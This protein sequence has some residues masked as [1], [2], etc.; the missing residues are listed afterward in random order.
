MTAGAFFVCLFTLFSRR[1]RGWMKRLSA[2]WKESGRRVLDYC[3]ATSHKPQGGMDGRGRCIDALGMLLVIPHC[4]NR[5]FTS[6][7]NT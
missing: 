5:L 7:S 6:I 4:R 3:C 1:R 2:G